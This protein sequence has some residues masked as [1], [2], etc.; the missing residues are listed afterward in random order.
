MKRLA[1]LLLTLTVS[2]FTHAADSF[3]VCWSIYV[4]W[5]PWGYGAEQKIVDKW[6]KKYG[7][8]IP[9]PQRDVHLNI[10]NEED[11]HSLPLQSVTGESLPL[12]DDK[13][14][15]NDDKK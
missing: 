9:F 12:K 11:K 10:V 3:K 8:E 6:A 5:M 4:G 1:A 15:N 14:K 7:I 13:S 2:S